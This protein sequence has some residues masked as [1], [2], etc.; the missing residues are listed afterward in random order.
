M[1]YARKRKPTALDV[2]IGKRL[3]ERRALAGLSQEKIAD[4]TN[5]TFQQIQKYENGTNRITAS[6]LYELARILRVPVA[7][8]YAGYGDNRFVSDYGYDDPLSR[9]DVM[10]L[11]RKYVR[12]TDKNPVHK[13][14]THV[15]FDTLLRCEA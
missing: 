6:R 3:R 10:A 11:V 5:L 14:T 15:F 1:P 4:K 7:F 12:L 8:F 9:K 13:K 2:H